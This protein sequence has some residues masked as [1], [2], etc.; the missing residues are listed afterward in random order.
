MKNIFKKHD[1]FKL[2]GIFLLVAIIFTWVMNNA[3]LSEGVLQA[4]EMNRAGIFDV[5]TYAQLS[6]YYFTVIFLFIFAVGGFY[7]FLGEVKAYDKLTSKLASVFNGKEKILAAVSML[8]F[9]VLASIVGEYLILFAIVPFFISIFAK[10]HV[11]KVTGFISTFGGILLG[12]IGATYSTK[13]V[14]TLANTTNGLGVTYGYETL[15][16]LI[17]AIIAYIMLLFFTFGR[18]DKNKKSKELSLLED[19]T[20]RV[21][22]KEVKGK[23]K[24]SK[25]SIIPISILLFITFA[26]LLVAFIGWEEAFGVSTFTELHSWINNATLFDVPVYKYILGN[27]LVEFGKWDLLMAGSL[28]IVVAFIIKLV[29]AIPFDKLIDGYAEGL[30]N[31]TKTVFLIVIVHLVLEISV[32]FPT[33]PNIVNSI[34][35]KSPNFATLLLSGAFTSIFAVDFQYVVSLIGSAFANFSNVN[36][37][38]LAL[39]T[40]YGIVGFMAPTSVILMLG[41]SYL[42]IKFKD[43]FKFIWKFF[44]LLILVVVIVLAILMYV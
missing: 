24:K 19:P 18:I 3:F 29:Y 16:V 22:E 1:L 6:F 34:L 14:G 30:K 40:A 13:I 43:Y 32:I 28:L 15:G 36:I 9:A 33:I 42:D 27:S 21:C 37:A 10:L 41:L 25:V 20:I 11:D 44:L 38:A 5:L 4:D 2:A 31:I 39:Q 35:G 26:M 12:I 8:L 17:I 23:K 7:G